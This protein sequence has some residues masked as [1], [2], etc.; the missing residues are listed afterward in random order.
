MQSLINSSVVGFASNSYAKNR[1]N[2]RKN[3]V[4]ENRY[5]RNRNRTI[6]TEHRNVS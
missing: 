3:N 5:D 4:I 2:K 6:K 1:E